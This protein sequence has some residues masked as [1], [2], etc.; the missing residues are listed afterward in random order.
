L[1]QNA[2]AEILGR[3]LELVSC[4][5]EGLGVGD[6][7]RE[8]VGVTTGV[9][10]IDCL[11]VTTG[12][13]DVSGTTGLTGEAVGTG[14]TD[15]VA[16]GEA[17]TDGLGEGVVDEVGEGEICGVGVDDGFGSVEDVESLTPVISQDVMNALKVSASTGS[18][19]NPYRTLTTIQSRT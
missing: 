8:G 17:V 6:G 3:L 10:L 4:V 9:G 18:A 13:G 7:E 15:A 14:M 16:V 5:T 1:A 12:V 11:G 2:P 19:V